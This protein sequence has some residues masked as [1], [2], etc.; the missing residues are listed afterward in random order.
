MRPMASKS[1]EPIT[2]ISAIKLGYKKKSLILFIDYLV[3]YFKASQ[4]KVTPLVTKEQ[5]K[6]IRD[7]RWKG[8]KKRVM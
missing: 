5:G 4:K 3:G 6:F 8:I 2:L 7:I 1:I